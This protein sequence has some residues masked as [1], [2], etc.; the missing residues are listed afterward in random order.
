LVSVTSLEKLALAERSEARDFWNYQLR[1]GCHEA[2]VTKGYSK[3][4]PMADDH[5]AR[6]QPK[7]SA[8]PGLETD[9]E[10]NII[11]FDRR[12]PEDQMKAAGRSLKNPEH[13][14][15]NPAPMQKDQ[16]GQGGTP[17][18]EDPAGQQGGYHE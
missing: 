18:Q 12:T 9:G 15:E 14:A 7:S 16:Q 6:M 8:P 5:K 4:T 1:N 13:E 10:G 2:A 3:E 17:R 11:P